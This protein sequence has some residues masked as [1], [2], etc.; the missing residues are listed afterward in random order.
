MNEPTAAPTIVSMITRLPR[1]PNARLGIR[2]SNSPHT[3][4][5]SLQTWKIATPLRLL[6][7]ACTNNSPSL[8]LRRV[9]TLGLGSRPTA[10]LSS[11][12]VALLIGNRHARGGHVDGALCIPPGSSATRI[13]CRRLVTEI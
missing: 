5:T 2:P 6:K 1:M 13:T 3:A 9:T 8:A 7:P 11:A 10:H 4:V 12:R